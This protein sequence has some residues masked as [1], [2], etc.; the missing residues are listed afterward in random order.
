MSDNNA[1]TVNGVECLSLY[2]AANPQLLENEPKLQAIANEVRDALEAKGL[3][4]QKI[5]DK[6][7][8][9]KKTV[10]GVNLCDHG[11]VGCSVGC[12]SSCTDCYIKP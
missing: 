12:T 1:I 3:D 7:E 9:Q 11:I 2:L 5:L 10:R 8:S 6:E 4:P